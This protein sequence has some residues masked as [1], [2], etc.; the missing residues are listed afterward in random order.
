M[1]AVAALLKIAFETGRELVADG[2][3]VKAA[4]AR[5]PIAFVAADA[6]LFAF[7]YALPGCIHSNIHR[8]FFAARADVFDF[9]DVVG[10]GEEIRRAR[11]WFAAE[12][13]TKAIADDRNAAHLSKTV[14]LA[15]LSWRQELSF[16]DE[17]ARD[18]RTLF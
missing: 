15:D 5:L 10:Q 17:Q 18:L 7:F 14:E 9:F 1:A 3:G 11:E 4:A 13:R 12:I 16:I 8:R 6:D 2:I